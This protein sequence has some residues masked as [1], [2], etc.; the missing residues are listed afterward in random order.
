MVVLEEVLDAKQDITL[1]VALVIV[2]LD[3]PSEAIDKFI[4][5]H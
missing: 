3:I 5:Q 2:A 4:I 1:E